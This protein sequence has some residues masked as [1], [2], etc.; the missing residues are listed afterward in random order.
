MSAQTFAGTRL[1][2]SQPGKHRR[3][4]AEARGRRRKRDGA[5]TSERDEGVVDPSRARPVGHLDI[6][7]VLLDQVRVIFLAIVV[8]RPVLDRRDDLAFWLGHRTP[9]V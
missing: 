2:R 7:L 6:E 8:G 4:T 3:T 1:D 9:L 5:G